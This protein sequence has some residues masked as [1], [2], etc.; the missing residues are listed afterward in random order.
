MLLSSIIFYYSWE[1]IRKSSQKTSKG[2]M[3]IH[4][5]TLIIFIDF[6]STT[7]KFVSKIL[8]IMFQYCFCYNSWHFLLNYFCFFFLS[9]LFI[10]FSFLLQFLFFSTI[11]ST[12]LPACLSVFFFFFCSFLLCLSLY[13]HSL[14][15]FPFFFSVPSLIFFIVFFVSVFSAFLS[16]GWTSFFLSFFLSFFIISLFNEDCHLYCTCVYYTH[17]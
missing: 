13:F 15:S 11:S 3:L 10:L 5:P 14:F 4:S 7:V 2:L 6:T 16:Y 1:V 12:S 9:S 8:K 17:P